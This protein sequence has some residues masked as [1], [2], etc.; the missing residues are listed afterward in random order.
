M[1]LQWNIFI[2]DTEV[3]EPQGLHE[4][5]LKISRHNEWH[6]VFIEASETP[7]QFTGAGADILK[8]EKQANGLNATATFRAEAD[9]GESVDVLEGSFDFGTY[10]EKCG[11][12]C[13][14]EINI[15]KTGCLTT[16]TNRYDQPVDLGKATAFD[17]MTLLPNYTGL[18]SNIDL[19]PQK[20]SIGNEAEM[21]ELPVSENL[22]DNINWADSDGFNNYIGWISPPLPI[23]TNESLG[24]FN[25]SPI[26]ELAGPFEG[27]PNKPPYPDFP[28]ASGTAT[29]LGDITCGLTDTTATF[30]VK[31]YAD[32]VFGG[33]GTFV[34]CILKLFRLPAGLDGTNFINWVEEYNVLLF[35]RG[36][37]SGH[38]TFDLAGTVP[39]TIAQG[40]FIYFG[41]STR[42]DS[43]NLIDEFTLTFEQ[44]T[45]FK[46]LS[47]ATCEA[48][49]ADT[50]LINETGARIIES[51]TDGCMTM[52]SDYYG[53]LDSEPYASEE[54]GC[55][56]LRVLTNGLKLRNATPSNHFISL[57]DFFNGLRGIDNI[58]MG[59]EPNTVLTT[60]EWMRIEPVEYFY[61]N[62][63]LLRLPFIPDAENR[64]MPDMG[65][66]TVK[67]GYQKWEVERV[68][69]LNEFNSNKLFRTSLKTINNELDA[70]SPFIAGGIPIEITRQ[71][72]FSTSGS[73]DTRY[74]NDNFIICVT[75]SGTY[76]VEFFASGDHMVFETSGD[77]SEFLPLTQIQIQGTVSNDGL[78]NIFVVSILTSTFDNRVTMDIG[79]TGGLTTDEVATGVTFANILSNTGVFVEQGNIANS[80][81]IFSPATAYNWRIRPMYNLMRW[82]KSIAHVYV[83]LGNSMSKIFFTSGTGNY[84]AEG[85]LVTPDSCRL[86]NG[87]LAE[88]QD[89][90]KADFNVLNYIDPIFKPETVDFEYPLSLSD[91][92][93]IKANPYG[94]IS[95]QCGTGAYEKAFIKTISYKPIEGKAN[96]TLIKKWQ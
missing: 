41:I 49:T 59:I 24:V 76:N 3:D 86:E 26:I 34:S 51:I 52:K 94:Y 23:V 67:I 60:Q 22:V 88:N 21:S 2:N 68:N 84:I 44:E 35:T 62:I 31:G 79:F 83:N 96:F 80:A 48:S 12:L 13:T 64:Q 77:G 20:I 4:L 46:L 95:I 63:E 91:Y 42:G 85:E 70:T 28:T 75:K 87:V 47:S 36:P 57:Q 39:L 7:L 58:G 25:S 10:N 37:T 92:L 15:E 53:R 81:N 32:L 82:F 27:V 65:Y 8:A 50:S 14:V 1:S 29:L 45:F 19:P 90:D 40:D 16:L 5:V 6:G 56:G 11:T 73:K 33:P 78:R 93:V 71:E 72:T 55:G 9:C 54:Q 18:L 89:L 61:Q 74:D 66:S 69:G 38:I 30:R 43:I 17:N